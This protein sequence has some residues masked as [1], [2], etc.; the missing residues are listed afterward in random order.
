M[1]QLVADP[2]AAAQL[3]PSIEIDL[4]SRSNRQTRV[5]P[6]QRRAS[7]SPSAHQCD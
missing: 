4:R 6:K 5:L 3:E 7:S 2:K 1:E